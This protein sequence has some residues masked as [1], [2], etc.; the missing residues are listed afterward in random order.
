MFSSEGKLFTLF[1]LQMELL[2]AR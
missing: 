1:I 2:G